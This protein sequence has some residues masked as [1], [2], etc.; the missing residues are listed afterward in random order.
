MTLETSFAQSPYGDQCTSRYG[1]MGNQR[2]ASCF[3]TLVQNESNCD[4]AH[5]TTYESNLS[6]NKS[7]SQVACVQT[8]PPL[9][10]NREEWR[11]WIFFVNRVPVYIC[12][13]YYFFCF[14]SDN[15][16][17]VE[18]LTRL[19]TLVQ[20]VRSYYFFLRGGGVCTQATRMDMDWKLRKLSQLFQVLMLCLQKSPKKI[21]LSAFWWDLF[22]FF[23]TIQEH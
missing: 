14:P 19:W 8:P 1:K 4:V 10:K 23:I 6:C 7:G 22:H 17:G 12:I 5:F 2:R 18:R 11:L 9:R 3:A 16:K 20:H 13:S 21:I 15:W